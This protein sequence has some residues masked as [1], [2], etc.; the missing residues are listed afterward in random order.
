MSVRQE[1]VA[2]LVQE[3]LSKIFIREISASELS[4]VTITKTRIS[5]DLKIA[6]VYISVYDKDKRDDV[7][8]YIE[9][10][11]GLIRFE[12]AKEANLRYTPELHFYIDDSLDYV[13]RM[14]DLL[15]SIKDVNNKSNET[16]ISE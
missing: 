1:K 3:V 13:E 4:L 15:N 2:G 12:L 11:K 7:L 9:T 6:K 16:D 8:Q 5:P 10:K 14:N